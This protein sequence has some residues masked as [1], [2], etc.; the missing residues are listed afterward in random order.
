MDRESEEE[1]HGVCCPG[2]FLCFPVCEAECSGVGCLHISRGVV[3]EEA[4]CAR[5]VLSAGDTEKT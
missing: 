1:T 4:F 3:G 2:S 5:H